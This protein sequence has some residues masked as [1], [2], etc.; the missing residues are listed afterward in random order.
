MHYHTP[1][2]NFNVDTR[3]TH[4]AFQAVAGLPFDE[5]E[6]EELKKRTR[7]KPEFVWYVQISDK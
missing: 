5:H 6:D 3:D 4:A 2:G 7:D 1:R